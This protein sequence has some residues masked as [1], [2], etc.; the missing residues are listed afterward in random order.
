MS[1]SLS[2][3]KIAPFSVNATDVLVRSGPSKAV[4]SRAQ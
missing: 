4:K 3:N 1:G 2:L